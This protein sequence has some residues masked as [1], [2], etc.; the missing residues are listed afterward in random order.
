MTQISMAQT[1][2]YRD[3]LALYI[4]RNTHYQLSS[5]IASARKLAQCGQLAT[6]LCLGFIGGE[7]LRTVSPPAWSTATTSNASWRRHAWDRAVPFLW[8]GHSL[9]QKSQHVHADRG[10]DGYGSFTAT[11]C[12]LASG[13]FKSYKIRV[14]DTCLILH[15][16]N[17]QRKT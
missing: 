6:L 8:H 1:S 12:L 17:I 14:F 10:I 3:I 16:L 13:I 5:R 15:L 4:S 11:L 2:I 7:D 9:Q